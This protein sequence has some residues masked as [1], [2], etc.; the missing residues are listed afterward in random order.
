MI[1]L[2]SN[3]KEKPWTFSIRYG[4][5]RNRMNG[6]EEYERDSGFEFVLFY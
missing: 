3:N 1:K 4:G 5:K 6:R 2:M